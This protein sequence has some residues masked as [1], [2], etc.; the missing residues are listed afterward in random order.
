MVSRKFSLDACDR[1]WL[2]DE[3]A[4]EVFGEPQ[5][6]TAGTLFP[7]AEAVPVDGGYRVT[8]RMPFVSLCQSATWFLAPAQILDGDTVRTDAAGIPE[9]LVVVYPA[10][11]A[12]IIDTWNTLGMR[13]TGSHD[14]AVLDVFVPEH[15]TTML[16]PWEE[17]GSAFTGPLYRCGV[18]INAPVVAIVNLASAAAALEAALGLALKK[19]PAYMVNP[20]RDRSVAQSQL[21]EAR[22]T[23][24]AGRASVMSALENVWAWA[25]DGYKATDGHKISLQLASTYGTQAAATAVALIHAAVG[26]SGI[27]KTK[28][29]ER[30]FR[31]VHTLTQHAFTSTSRYESVG[32]MMVGFDTDWGFL[33]L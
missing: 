26:T 6:I 13:G 14:V 29:F 18:M 17:P 2:P 5:T 32:K 16:R 11:D 9:P 4:A 33:T 24:E 31:D 10:R 25:L 28:A 22:A 27:R 3:G 23:I 8:G 15:R 20:L 1:P 30:H 7:P 19:T 21:A 12:E